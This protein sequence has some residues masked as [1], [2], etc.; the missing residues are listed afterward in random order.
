MTAAIR[1]ERKGVQKNSFSGK[2][3][4]FIR[5]YLNHGHIINYLSIVTAQLSESK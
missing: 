5:K 2:F 4:F 1:T 3:N